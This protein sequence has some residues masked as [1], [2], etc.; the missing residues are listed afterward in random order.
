MA[1]GW[2]LKI[3]TGKGASRIVS[4][5]VIP[6]MGLKY[7]KMLFLYY[8]TGTAVASYDGNITFYKE[9]HETD[10]EKGKLPP[11]SK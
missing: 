8:C 4:A 7:C 5:K 1:Q 3:F 9:N 2:R 6:N 11:D 10:A